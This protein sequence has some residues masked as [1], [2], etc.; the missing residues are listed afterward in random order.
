[1][2]PRIIPY[3]DCL[4]VR[5]LTRMCVE[6]LFLV[7]TMYSSLLTL[8]VSCDRIVPGLMGLRQ[9]LVQTA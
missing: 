4:V 6:L 3:E 5:V 7:E 1:M 9:V 2:Q 8:P